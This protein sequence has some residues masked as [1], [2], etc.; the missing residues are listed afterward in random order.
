[1][2]ADGQ[3][4]AYLALSAQ[5]IPA[6]RAHLPKTLRVHELYSGYELY[7]RKYIALL[8]IRSSSHKVCFTR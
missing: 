4:T 5:D 3:G 1:V 2:V 7:S 6:I 8:R